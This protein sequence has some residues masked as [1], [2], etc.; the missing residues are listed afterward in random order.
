MAMPT[1]LNE[2]TQK[3]IVEAISTGNYMETAARYAGIDRKTFYNWMERGAGDDAE[4]LYREFRE[5]VEEAKAAAE[6]RAVLRITQAANDGTWQA[7]AW[8][9]E[10]TRPKQWG[11]QDRTEVTGPEGG[12]VKIDVTAEELENKIAQLLA[13]RERK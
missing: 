3:R 2:T 4:P 10:R 6:V 9:L 12:A 13:Q 7:A 8:W 1:K 11:R 5:A